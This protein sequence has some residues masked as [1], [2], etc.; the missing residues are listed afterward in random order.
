MAQCLEI[1][2]N[3]GASENVRP[4]SPECARDVM[5]NYP[6]MDLKAA[7]AECCHDVN[8]QHNQIKD[9]LFGSMNE[10]LLAHKKGC[11][12]NSKMKQNLKKIPTIKGTK[13]N[14]QVLLRCNLNYPND[15]VKM[16]DGC[17]N[18]TNNFI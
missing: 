6:C 3:P 2:A 1:R 15:L 12:S 14:V 10:L 7:L 8:E 4:L 9:E 11:C 16:M 18:N 13:V 17:P 5:V